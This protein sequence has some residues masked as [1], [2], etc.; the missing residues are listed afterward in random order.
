VRHF[1][2]TLGRRDRRAERRISILTL[3]ASAVAHLVLLALLLRAAPPPPRAGAP[4]WIFT[5]VLDEPGGGGGSAGDVQ[6]VQL[7]WGSA[8]RR[9]ET[10]EP[11]TPP[12]LEPIEIATPV[13]EPPEA[14]LAL[15][16]PEIERPAAIPPPP[17]SEAAGS[18]GLRPAGIGGGAGGGAGAGVGSGAGLGTGPGSGAGT[19]PGGDGIR[20]PVP[21]TILVPP[22]ATDAVRGGSAMVRLQV[23][24]AGRVR[25]ADVVVSSGD[26]RYDE[27]L[28]RV[29]LGW[30][31]RP[32]RDGANRPVPY[33]FEVSVGF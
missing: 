30:R 29:A 21:L 17:P 24:T 26:R 9:P 20:P 25:T 32:A 12:E 28:R 1:P 2:A 23:D 27:Q 31:F 7:A 11:P 8:P 13:I 14:E 16:A 22:A 19:G 3:G 18:G 6:I 15:D 33:P 5:D 4:S 10:P